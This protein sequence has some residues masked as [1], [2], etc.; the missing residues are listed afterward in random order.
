MEK[1]V[2]EIPVSS[3]KKPLLERITIL[4]NEFKTIRSSTI[5]EDSVVGDRKPLQG[6]LGGGP[7]SLPLP[8]EPAQN[9]QVL[10]EFKE[11]LTVYEKMLVVLN[12]EVEKLTDVMESMERQRRLEMDMIENSRP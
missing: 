8:S 9:S 6:L 11:K 2:G 4:E 10:K 5:E 12:R 3:S 1:T 7:L